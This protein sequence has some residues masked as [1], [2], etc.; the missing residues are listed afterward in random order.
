[1][2][3]RHHLNWN[4]SALGFLCALIAAAMQCFAE[5]AQAEGTVTRTISVAGLQRSYLLHVPRKQLKEAPSALVLMFHGGGG[6]PAFAARDSR[7]SELADREGFLVAY[8][9]GHKKS[10]ND[11]RYADSIGAQRDQVNDVD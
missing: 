11:G 1:M 8:P 2:K 10:W 9:E 6:T 7:F 3:L 5:T 4:L